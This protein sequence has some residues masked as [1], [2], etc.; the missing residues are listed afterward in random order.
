M[1]IDL[2]EKI[3][4]KYLKPNIINEWVLKENIYIFKLKN[5]LFHFYKISNF[6]Y[7]Y[8]LFRNLNILKR[9]KEIYSFFR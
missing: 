1:G 7:I 5:T 3:E 2:D 4:F 8:F 6:I 9:V